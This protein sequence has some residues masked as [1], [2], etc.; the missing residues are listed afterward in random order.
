MQWEE[1]NVCVISSRNL[2][3]SNNECVYC[4]LYG[5]FSAGL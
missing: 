2:D 3:D 5:E 1:E 4:I